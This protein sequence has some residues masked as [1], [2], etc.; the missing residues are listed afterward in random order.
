MKDSDFNF[1]LF[2]ILQLNLKHKIHII[3]FKYYKHFIFNYII[4]YKMYSFK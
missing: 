4:Y 1:K 3:I 2:V